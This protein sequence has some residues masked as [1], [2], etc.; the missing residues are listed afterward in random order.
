MAPTPSADSGVS[1]NPNSSITALRSQPVN[2]PAK[3]STNQSTTQP[4]K[5]LQHPAYEITP[6]TPSDA[7]EIAAL[8]AEVWIASFGWSVGR[9]EDLDAY[10][11]SSYTAEVWASKDLVDPQGVTYIA[12]EIV[13][14]EKDEVGVE[15]VEEVKGRVKGKGKLL[16][17][18]QLK[19]GTSEPCVEAHVA[20]QTRP[21]TDTLPLSAPT[22]ETSIPSPS[23]PISAPIPAPIEASNTHSPTHNPALAELHRLYVSTASQGRG[24]GKALVRHAERAAVAA[25]AQ[26]M[27]LGVWEHNPGAR[28]L[29]AGLGYEGVG[30]HAFVIGDEV[31]SDL[32]WVRRL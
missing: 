31:Q 29:Y 28:R 15:R 24:I 25:G 1:P 6:A 12:R 30:E 21:T 19:F 8:G 32:V 18:A 20:G 10:I 23:T 2:Q 3:Q 11:A 16:G 13:S 4:L 7:P 9:Q 22:P 17:F 26:W 5:P 27:W 14:T